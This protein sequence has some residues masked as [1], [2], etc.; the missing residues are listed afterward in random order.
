MLPPIS[1]GAPDA[2]EAEAGQAAGHGADT[3]PPASEISTGTL[4]ADLRAPETGG[5]PSHP[6]ETPAT[7][8]PVASAAAGPTEH[9]TVPD[10]WEPESQQG[11]QRRTL[12]VLRTTQ[13]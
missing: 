2:E 8:E 7:S 11:I 5:D 6:G 9:F 10:D 4:E 13:A 12:V 1:G 3:A